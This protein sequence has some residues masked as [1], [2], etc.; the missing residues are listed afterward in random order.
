MDLLKELEPYNNCLDHFSNGLGV[1]KNIHDNLTEVREI[2][3]RVQIKHA[4]EIYGRS[5][6]KPIECTSCDTSMIKSLYNLRE[7]YRDKLKDTT[8]FKGVPQTEVKITPVKETKVDEFDQFTGADY[9]KGV[10][11]KK[12]DIYAVKILTSTEGA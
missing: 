7:K 12:V 10:P 5:D 4:K 3:R 2:W 6:A 1:S 11:Q 8:Y 9:S